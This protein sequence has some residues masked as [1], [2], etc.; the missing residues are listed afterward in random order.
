GEAVYRLYG[1]QRVPGSTAP[2]GRPDR[3]RG[4][5]DRPSPQPVQPWRRSGPCRTGRHPRRH[6]LAG[7]VGGPGPLPWG[8]DGGGNVATAEEKPWPFTVGR[9]PYELKQ[10]RR[11]G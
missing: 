8:G 1:R 5:T 4:A 6:T 11:T 2:G 3:R 9:R 7:S 10:N